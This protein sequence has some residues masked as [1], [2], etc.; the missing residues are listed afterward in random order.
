[1]KRAL[2][3]LALA[4]AAALVV[5]ALV[6]ARTDEE[7]IRS[8]LRDVAAAVAPRGAGEPMAVRE[9]RIARAFGEAFDP[10]VSL[11][12]QELGAQ[13]RG[14]AALIAFAASIPRDVEGLEFDLDRLSVKFDE[15]HE[16][17]LA[18]GPV[19]L[20]V[21]RHG[22]ARS[23]DLRTLALRF[24]RADGEWRIGDLSASGRD[25]AADATE[26]VAPRKPTEP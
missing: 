12:I 25:G 17:A 7:R 2:P 5:Y 11:A 1:M 13:A 6:F 19:R 21:S 14:R 20:L 8:R 16:H 4:A 3:L 26:R 15:P 9:A 18:V 22:G 24:D 23:E 10:D